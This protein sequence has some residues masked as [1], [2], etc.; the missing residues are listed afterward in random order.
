MIRKS[1]T[2]LGKYSGPS[3]PNAEEEKLP[4]TMWDLGK[5]YDFK[6]S[7]SKQTASA[8]LSVLIYQY[9]QFWGS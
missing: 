7:N 2:K 8:F 9:C 3:G 4:D 5:I 6:V 1:F